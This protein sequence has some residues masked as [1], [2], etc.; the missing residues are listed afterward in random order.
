MKHRLHK[1]L[2]AATELSRR[3]AEKAIASG[4]VTVNGKV[5]TKLGVLADPKVDVIKWKGRR[6][7]PPREKIYI[8]YN[9]PKGTLVTKSD[10]HG[11]STIWSDLKQYKDRVNAVGRLDYDSEGLLIMTNDGELLNRLTHPRHDIKKIYNVKVK[12]HPKGEALDKIR[13]GVRYRGISYN[14]AFIKLRYVTENNT[15]LEVK[16]SE[17]KNRMVRKIFSAVGHPVQKLKRFAVGPIRLGKMEASQWRHLRRDEVELLLQEV[18]LMKRPPRRNVKRAPRPVRRRERSSKSGDINMEKKIE[19][20]YSE[21]QINERLDQLAEAI[22]KDYGGEEITVVGV[23]K[24]AF[25]FMADLVRRLKSPIKCD[26]VRVASYEND[27]STGYVRMEFD[28][29]QPIH[30][31]HVLLIEDIVDSGRT[32]EYLLK[33]LDQQNPKSL[34]TCTLLHKEDMGADASKIDYKGFT[35]PN[36]YVIGYGLDS[37][38]LYRSLPYVGYFTE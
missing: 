16:I 5:V 17:G 31:Q 12:G 14:P 24:G 30:D 10:P 7:Q 22:D 15:W 21:E 29:T 23:L 18:G 34:K 37:V 8:I 26:F 36:K 11:R 28:M 19:K 2:A 38:G 35:V 1:I 32:L 25:I 9:K 13:N 27:E 33:H 6:V 4:E 3:V 20:L